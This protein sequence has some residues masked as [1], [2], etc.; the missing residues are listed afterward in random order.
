M[1]GGTKYRGTAKIAR[2]VLPAGLLLLPSASG[3]YTQALATSY[4]HGNISNTLRRRR[5]VCFLTGA[6]GANGLIG[7]DSGI[8]WMLAFFK[9]FSFACRA[10]LLVSYL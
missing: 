8:G 5:R 6:T 9:S 2:G 1:P 10:S 4:Y 7:M 3:D